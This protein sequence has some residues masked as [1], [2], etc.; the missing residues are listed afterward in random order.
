MKIVFMGTPDLAAEILQ[1]ISNSRHTV[2]AVVT[3]ADKPKGR[4][5]ELA[6][7]AVKVLAKELGIPVYQPEKVRCEEAYETF[8]SFD[9]DIFVVA[10]Y[11]KILPKEILEIPEKGCI[12]VHTSLLPKY[13]GSAPIQWAIIEG[14]QETG[15]TVMQMDEGMDTGDILFT[16]VVPV[17]ADE[18]GGSLFDKLASAGAELIVSA[19]DEIEAGNVHP[20]K[21]DESKASYAK[22]L[23]K[24]LGYVRF[25]RSAAEIERLIR[26]LDP[27][28]STY[29]MYKDKT[30]K[31]W[32]AEVIN[33]KYAEA[34][35]TVIQVDADAIYVNTSDGVLKITE[36]Q[37]EGKRRMKTRDFLLGY[38]IEVG[39]VLG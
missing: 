24:K 19:L 14:E 32:K 30:L 38:K 26:G 3:Q 33:K 9:A 7:P 23:N 13:R 2:T 6:E 15:V 10:A 20:V 1:S 37:L 25:V 34:P 11:G 4:G 12:N 8:R 31:L 16:K 5:K 17:A 18:T 21:Q 28:P 35:G 29:T 27:W 36:L 22:M 39:D